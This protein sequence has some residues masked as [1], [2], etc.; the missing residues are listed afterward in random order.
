MSKELVSQGTYWH[1]KKNPIW[2]C[3]LLL[4]TT[5]IWTYFWLA[6]LLIE[7]HLKALLV[8]ELDSNSQYFVNKFYVYLI[9]TCLINPENFFSR[10]G[11][12]GTSV[13]GTYSQSYSLS[14][15]SNRLDSCY[16]Y[17]DNYC[18]TYSNISCCKSRKSLDIDSQYHFF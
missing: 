2:N 18:Y 8:T 9:C 11:N 7:T 12:K 6:I 14:C 3:I 4:I 17:V 10:G 16:V 1:K 5:G 15:G 13:N